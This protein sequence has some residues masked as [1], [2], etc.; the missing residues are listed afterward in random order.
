MSYYAQVDLML[1]NI[2]LS[3]QEKIDLTIMSACNLFHINKEMI[4]SKSRLREVVEPRQICMFVFYKRMK[5]TLNQTGN[6]FGKDHSTV[7]HAVKNVKNLME[8]DEE[9]KEKAMQIFK[10]TNK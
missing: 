2:K 6:I 3:N 10:H 4:L 1:Q 8:H 9:F 7:I 5:M